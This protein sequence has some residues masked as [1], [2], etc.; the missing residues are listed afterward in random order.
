[1]TKRVI[2]MSDYEEPTWEEYTGEDPPANKWFNAKCTRARFDEDE[3]Q[4]IFILEITDG[5]YKGWGRGWYG[6]LEG[7]LKWKSQTAIK[8]LTG[9]TKSVT[10]DF[11]NEK[12]VAAWVAK[13]RPVKIKTRE[14]N[15][16]VSIN[17]IA[18]LL[19]GVPTTP[20]TPAPKAELAPEPVP[21][22]EAVEDYTAEELSEMSVEDLV[23]VLVEEFEFE[24]ADMPEKKAGRGAAAK[25]KQ[26]LVDAILEAQEEGDEDEDG[27]EG[28]AED[29]DFEDGFDEDADEEPEPEP[30]PEPAPRARRSRAAK[31]APAKAAPAA[32]ATTTRRRR[33]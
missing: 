15:D 4:V 10:V 30:E 29:E 24:D 19:E 8:A 27:E 17:R 33:A 25:Y 5:D 20:G 14:Y 22:D 21:D 13:L 16:K 9:S 23:E 7:E 26:A 18:P 31:P 3:N 6:P 1:M 2:D 12:A 28:D 32:K 11:D